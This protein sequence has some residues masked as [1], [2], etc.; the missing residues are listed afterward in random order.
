MESTIH[1]ISEPLTITELFDVKIPNNNSKLQLC[2]RAYVSNKAFNYPV[3]NKFPVELF[4][5]KKEGDLVELN[6]FG[7]R[8]SV[9]LS[10]LTRDFNSFESVL[11]Y[12][13][14]S[15]TGVSN[16]ENY[17]PKLSIK[18]QIYMIISSSD[19]YARSI[20]KEP[21][22]PTMFIRGDLFIELCE[23]DS[24]KVAILSPMER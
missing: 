4:M 3:S 2:F 6:L 10:Q 24:K 15:F 8:Y 5:G 12:L 21:E 20:G 13:T 14:K 7:E 9:R 16:P 18:E 11:F 19:K 22:N 23:E 17:H 1:I